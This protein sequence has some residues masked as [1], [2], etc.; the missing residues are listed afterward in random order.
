MRLFTPDSLLYPI[1]VTKLLRQEGD[2][3]DVNAP[4]FWYEYKTKIEEFDDDIRD[5]KVN[6]RSQYGSF[7]SETEGKLSAFKVQ[8]G[9]VI[10]GRTFVADVEEPCT[11]DVQF[12]NICANCGKD[13]TSLATYNSTQSATDRA[14]TNIVHGRQ[15]LLISAG[16]AARVDEEGKRRLLQSRRLS[17]VVDLDQT[18]IHASV[19]PT[20]A[21]WQSDPSNPNYEALQDVQKFQLD[22]DKPNTWYYIKPRPGLKQFLATLSEIYEMHIYTMGTRAYAES[23]AKIIDPDKK[24][25][26]DR[27]LSR[28]ESGSMT[29][30][31][32]KRLFPVDTRMVVIIDDRADVWHWTSNLIKVNVFE[33]FVGIGDINSSFLP[34][35]PELE[36]LKSVAPK[37][38]RTPSKKSASD[39]SSTEADSNESSPASSPSTAPTTPPQTNGEVSAVEQMVSMAGKQDA[40]SIKEKS[41]LQEQTIAEQV[42]ERPMLKKQ[43]ELERL[44]KEEEAK[45][46][47]KDDEAKES[48]AVEATAELLAGNGANKETSTEPVQHKYRHNLLANDDTELIYLEQSLRSVHDAYYDE[49]DKNASGTKGGRIAQ[50]RPGH[51]K[52][53][54]IDDLENIP[55]AAAIMDRMK[56]KVLS[57]VHLVFSGVV[58]LGVDIHSH[59]TA[60][61]A[62][63]FGA[64]VSE[65]ITKKTT[66]VIASPERRT[67]KVRQAAKKSGRIAIVSQHWLHACF[68]QWKKVEENPYRIHS[69]APANGTAGLPDSFEGHEYQLSESDED[70]AQTEDE[71]DAD[72][73]NGNANGLTLDIPT[74]VDTDSEEW[75]KH[76]PTLD[77]Q[78]SSPTQEE[79]P[80]KWDDYDAEFEE[81]MDGE[82]LDTDAEDSQSDR[83]DDAGNPETPP[84]HRKRKSGDR[85][86]ENESD[87]EGSRLQKRKKEAIE[88]TSSLTNLVKQDGT[89]LT[90][91]GDDAEADNDDDEDDLDLEAALAAEM[92]RQSSEDAEAE[93]TS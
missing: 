18:I 71:T 50:L 28:N 45:E 57:G 77:R 64:T 60:V 48:P 54:S 24:I 67:A 84:G 66:H 10:R 23:V 89:T 14:T 44:A 46:A 62:K 49:L 43:Q 74:D 65:N 90:A 17:L 25:F 51:S 29:A 85:D 11:H 59:D 69:D 78:D 42:E 7:E 5:Y 1:T 40:Q 32:L 33:F 68:A 34:K 4:L 39:D 55:D 9:Q 72:T 22:D 86:I 27:I 31:N 83:T 80:D 8:V 58:P 53:R 87:A 61:W 6:E 30:K 92:E 38:E 82:D 41:E 56:A 91:T 3:I 21:E 20:I 36:A 93:A 19:E 37:M 26:G 70:A 52:K 73:P 81:Y 13:L 16:E 12:G 35:R 79:A 15:D 47:T 2:D 63:S 75:L 76:A 88:R